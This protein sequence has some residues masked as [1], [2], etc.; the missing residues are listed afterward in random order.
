MC[1]NSET[2]WTFATARFSVRLEIQFDHGYQYDGDDENGETQAALDAGDY[3][4]FDSR[5]VVELD[6]EEIAS[7]SLGGSVYDTNT[8]DEF[9]TAHRDRDPMNRNCSAMRAARG[10]NVC[11]GHYF[12]SMVAEAIAAARAFLNSAPRLR[13][14]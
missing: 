13:A 9:W 10:G 4:A 1:I 5:V 7:D 6:G 2:V 8:V 11:I 3:V 14:A 12:P